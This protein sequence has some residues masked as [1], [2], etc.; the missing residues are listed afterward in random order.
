M[1]E[2]D[3]INPYNLEK[4]TS[5]ALQNAADVEQA[6]STADAL[7]QDRQRH[8]SV[9]QR[10]SILEK[11]QQLMEQQVD[12]LTRIAAAEGGKPYADSKVEV[13]RAINGVQ[14]AIEHIAHNED[15]FVPM[16]H[17]DASANRLA[18]NLRE[19]IGVA[20]GISAFNHP[21]NLIVHQTIPP[22]AVGCPVIIKPDLRTP[23]SCLKLVEIL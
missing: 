6:L 4:I 10:I 22:I 19:P 11:T 23:M 14:L 18:M 3:I 9:P 2:V 5:I 15:Q 7:F 21:L 13:L 8:L 16:G 1:S 20:T 12:E 17:T